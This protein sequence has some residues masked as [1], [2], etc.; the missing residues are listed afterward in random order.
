[1]SLYVY[2]KTRENI[3]TFERIIEMIDKKNQDIFVSV[4]HKRNFR[5]LEKIKT[6]MSDEDV[7]IIGTL[8]SLGLNEA[9]VLNELNYFIQNRKRLVICNIESTYKFGISQPVNWAV[10]NTLLESILLHN[11]NV[12]KLPENKRSNA[13]RNKIEFPDNWEELY[14]KW[15]DN[16]ISSKEFLDRSGLK[17]ATF[18]NMITEY[19]EILEANKSFIKK[20]RLG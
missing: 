5:E 7:L 16:K 2:T 10:L 17:R 13:G 11:T 19:R 18:Y 15:E 20:Y 4:E 12:I 8:Q 1:M 3:D 14:E 6:E 9:D